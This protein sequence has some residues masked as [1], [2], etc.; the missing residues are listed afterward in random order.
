[1]FSKML[2]LLKLN[3]TWNLS[4]HI[5][6]YLSL[7]ETEAKVLSEKRAA[8]GSAT[9]FKKEQL[10]ALQHSLKKNSFWLRNTV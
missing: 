8:S 9:L 4:C 6:S 3:P 10:R 7:S 1:M 2:K 5:F